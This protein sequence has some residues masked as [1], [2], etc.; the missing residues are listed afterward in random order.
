MS[1]D[2]QTDER[3]FTLWRTRSLQIAF[4]VALTIRLVVV[5]AADYEFGR[6]GA[7]SGLNAGYVNGAA[8]LASG[9]GLLMHTR[10]SASASAVDV[11]K[12]LEISGTRLD[13]TH[14]YPIDDRGWIPA[15]FHPAGYSVLLWGFYEIGNYR[16]IYLNYL[17]IQ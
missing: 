5:W 7:L 12:N 17:L 9:M 8:S 13:K 2:L 3:C 4:A 11:M 1:E 15:T 6:G 14:P 16:G 10:N